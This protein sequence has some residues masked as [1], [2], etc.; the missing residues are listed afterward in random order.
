MEENVDEF[1][2]C[3]GESLSSVVPVLHTKST[4]HPHAR[5]SD[6]FLFIRR[7]CTNTRY[8]GRNESLF[9]AVAP[10]TPPLEIGKPVS[11]L[12]RI[13]PEL[14]VR[15]QKFCISPFVQL[16]IDGET[17]WIRGIRTLYP[18]RH[19]FVESTIVSIYNHVRELVP[20]FGWTRT[21]TNKDIFVNYDRIT[22][23]WIVPRDRILTRGICSVTGRTTSQY[24]CILCMSLRTPKNMTE[25][26]V[27]A[28]YCKRCFPY[29]PSGIS[30]A[31][32]E[33]F[34]L[35][36]LMSYIEDGLRAHLFQYFWPPTA[37]M[38]I[39]FISLD[40]PVEKARDVKYMHEAYTRAA[41]NPIAALQGRLE[42]IDALAFAKTTI[43]FQP[44]CSILHSHGIHPESM[45]IH[46]D[47]LT[48][49][50]SSITIPNCL[51]NKEN[52]IS[53][54][55]PIAS[56]IENDADATRNFRDTMREI[57][58]WSKYMNCLIHH[59]LVLFSRELKTCWS[60]P[61]MYRNM[62]LAYGSKTLH[63]ETLPECEPFTLHTFHA[64]N[65]YFYRMSDIFPCIAPGFKQGAQ[66]LL[67]RLCVAGGTIVV[68]DLSF[69]A[70]HLHVPVHTHSK[71]QGAVR[72]LTLY[73]ALYVCSKQIYDLQHVI[74]YFAQNTDAITIN[75]LSA[76]L[77]AFHPECI[78]H[79]FIAPPTMSMLSLKGMEHTDQYLVSRNDDNLCGNLCHTICDNDIIREHA[80]RFLKVDVINSEFNDVGATLKSF[81]AV[82]SN[83]KIKQTSVESSN[84][85][86]LLQDNVQSKNECKELG[87]PIFH[88]IVDL[89]ATAKVHDVIA[90]CLGCHGSLC[91]QRSQTHRFLSQ[92]EVHFAHAFS[93]RVI[94]L[95]SEIH[96]R[97]PAGVEDI[98]SKIE[99]LPVKIEYHSGTRFMPGLSVAANTLL[100]K[101]EPASVHSQHLQEKIYG[102]T[103][104]Q[105]MLKL[106]W[107][108]VN[109]KTNACLYE[110]KS[111]PKRKAGDK[112]Q[113]ASKEE[114]NDTTPKLKQSRISLTK[115]K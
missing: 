103:K 98:L 108:N 110:P 77:A 36:E 96:A 44:L 30:H 17:F 49:P 84:W 37:W 86:E 32:L 34:Q 89:S 53:L 12:G 71:I 48:E 50:A 6:S 33:N 16:E 93:R 115:K 68:V 111:L 18:K 3:E 69:I 64:N 1:V 11:E 41:Q 66:Q 63:K 40:T 82:F 97:K 101:H 39:A 105:A 85:K 72:R 112:S 13:S 20:E 114:K 5:V 75:L 52:W 83:E 47:M 25:K 78:L 8:I 80:Q 4:P 91:G 74:I 87:I 102:L 9:Y 56:I 95:V 7:K 62:S 10:Q 57:A 67:N 27:H 2:A 19:N 76:Q 61:R 35:P 92:A 22:R 79:L 65:I 113:T 29:V 90:L 46:I 38:A 14:H 45:F 60:L 107:K 109:D 26:Y 24:R 94:F 28:P 70:G 104:W 51:L 54:Y 58:R 21:L 43:A 31:C 99:A 106:Y 81:L 23:T 100:N 59:G 73:E 55:Q 42:G 88:S 15:L